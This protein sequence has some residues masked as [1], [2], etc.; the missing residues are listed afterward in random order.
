MTK[1]KFTEWGKEFGPIFSLNLAGQPAIV[2]NTGK[3]CADLM[4]RRSIIYS[5]RPRF[6]MAA[7]ILTGGMLVGF[8]NYGSV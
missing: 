7:E 6:I 5:D 4:D 2:L 3:V 1:V 8:A